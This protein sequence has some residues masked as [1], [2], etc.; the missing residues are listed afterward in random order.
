VGVFAAGLALLYPAYQA[1]LLD[2]WL[3]IF[4][5]LCVLA[6]CLVCFVLIRKSGENAG[7]ELKAGKIFRDCPDCPEMIVIPAGGFDMGTNDA[8]DDEKPVHRVTI[9]QPFALGKIEVTQAE[10]SAVMGGNPSDISYIG[11]NY[12]VENVSWDDAQEFIRRLNQITGKQYRLPREAEWEFACHAKEK[13]PYC[14]DDDLANAAWYGAGATAAGDASKLC[15]QTNFYGLCDKSRNVWEWVE[16]NY[17]ENYNGAPADGS[18]RQGNNTVRVLRGGS[19]G[20]APWGIGEGGRIGCPPEI[21]SP[22]IG[23]R[24]ARTLS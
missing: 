19:W 7:I 5:L 10:W 23:F 15:E 12:P 14:G 8:Q 20:I 18:A 4:G 21:C 2:V 6:T 22:N 16:D 17:H 9:S 13:P 3:V 11:D 1:G 24:L